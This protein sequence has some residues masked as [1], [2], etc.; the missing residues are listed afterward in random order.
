MK[1][2]AETRDRQ[3]GR[4]G[5]LVLAA[6]TVLIFA[7]LAWVFRC[8]HQ[9]GS[10]EQ[11]VASW[12]TAPFAGPLWCVAL[13]ALQVV[14]FFIPGEAISFTAGYVFGTWHGFAYSLAGIT[15][16]SAFNF[17][18][19]RLVGRPVLSRIVRAS[20]LER[21]DQLLAGSRGRRAIF[22]AFLFPLGPKDAF[23]YGAAFS[24]MSLPELAA[25]SGSARF[26][27]LLFSVY[28]GTNTAHR[29]FDF[30]IAAGLMALATAGAFYLFRRRQT[31]CIASKAVV[32]NRNGHTGI[33]T[34][35]PAGCGHIRLPMLEQV[36]MGQRRRTSTPS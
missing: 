32:E 8:W 36:P 30:V 21:V 6:T 27:G 35:P 25:I 2:M 26:P 18:L 29:N 20:S 15:L 13:Q 24:G 7:F 11:L 14:S 5:K 33:G 1:D 16:G 23:C 4:G 9:A 22:L 3:S 28:L 31:A 10:F 12:R 34:M 17:H 19:A